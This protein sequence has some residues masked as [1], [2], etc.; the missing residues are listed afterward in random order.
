[1]KLNYARLR[2][3]FLRAKEVPLSFLI[4]KVWLL[5]FTTLAYP[6]VRLKVQKGYSLYYAKKIILAL[7][8][9][10]NKINRADFAL[11]GDEVLFL[12]RR[13]DDVCKGRYECLG[14][15][16]VEITGESWRRDC[17]HDASWDYIYFSRIDFV[18]ADRRSDIKIV[19]EKSRLQF[20]TEISLLAVNSKDE[21][22]ESLVCMYM[23][24]VKDWSAY[25]KFCFGPNWI[26]GMEVAIRAVNI[27]FS[28]YLIFDHLNKEQKEFIG[29]LLSEHY[30]YL[31][32]F[33]EISDIEGNHSLANQMGSEVFRLMG[34]GGSTSN[35]YSFLDYAKGQFTADGLHIEFSP[36]YHR[37]CL[38]FLMVAKMAALINQGQS[39]LTKGLV[40]LLKQGLERCIELEVVK[41]KL[42]LFGDNDSG[43][44]FNFGQS[45]VYYSDIVGVFRLEEIPCPAGRISSRFYRGFIGLECNVTFQSRGL[46]SAVFQPYAI[47]ASET[48]KVISRIGAYGLSGRAP[49]DHDDNL[50]FVLGSFDREII[51]DSGCPPYTLNSRLREQ[52]I[53][54]LA[55]NVVQAVS[56]PRCEFSQ[57]SIFKTVM[58]APAAHLTSFS[59]NKLIGSMSFNGNELANTIVAHERSFTLERCEVRDIVVVE[60]KFRYNQSVRSEHRIHFSP[61][62]RLNLI[63]GILFG[64]NGAVNFKVE[65]LGGEGFSLEMKLGDYDYFEVYGG[66]SKATYLSVITSPIVCGHLKIIISLYKAV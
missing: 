39:A 16:Y 4:S 42:P 19:W 10:N 17:L 65:A 27:I 52:A 45:A 26:V 44:V 41:G 29:S 24:L 5:L 35:N 18:D 34:C 63:D 66:C 56:V 36:T 38:E 60:D 59:E 23:R 57:G 47:I 2:Y 62:V 6:L 28:A 21:K 13:V 40:V 9:G 54:S 12:E 61:E 64:R 20:L 15:G 7:E 32:W 1:M 43:H 3:I 58:G 31:K 55:H 51:V 11:S 46:R 50:S 53:G 14:Y 30:L 48:T 8:R 22:L 37:L 49:H 25:N 33:P